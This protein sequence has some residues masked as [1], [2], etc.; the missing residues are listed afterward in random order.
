ML[1]APDHRAPAPG[2]RSFGD[3]AGDLVDN[4]KAYARAEVDY[5]KAVATEKLKSLRVAAALLVVA[6]FVA[7]GA[8]NTLCI[9]IYV[10]LARFLGPLAGGIA[11]F[12]LIGAI[13]GLLAWLGARKLGE[14]L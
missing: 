12:V 5:A 4:A 13:A 8:L 1:K 11:A 9:G 7:M 6:L 10:A 14:S 3:L 2:D